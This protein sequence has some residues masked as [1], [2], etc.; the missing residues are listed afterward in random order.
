MAMIQCSE[1]AAVIS[2][3]AATCPTCGA[4]NRKRK[5]KTNSTMKSILW[6]IGLVL[7]IPVTAFVLVEVMMQVS[8]SDPRHL[9]AKVSMT[10]GVLT[11]TNVEKVNW[12]ECHVTANAN[13][14]YSSATFSL[15]AGESS[16]L[17]LGEF[18][19]DDGLRFSPFLYKAK[20][21][22]IKCGEFGDQRYALMSD[23]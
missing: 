23:E 18:V 22:K 16:T 6:T 7:V 17:P 13:H 10:A 1:C 11:V 8:G 9:N 12:V 3:Q 2:D 14:D 5:S 4:P 15:S 21:F 19:S 20:T